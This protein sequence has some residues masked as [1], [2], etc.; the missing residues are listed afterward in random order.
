VEELN[1]D[2]LDEVVYQI[3][4]RIFEKFTSAVKGLDANGS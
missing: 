1:V 4:D 2:N 3:S